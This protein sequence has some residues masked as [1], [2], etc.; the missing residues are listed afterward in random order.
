MYFEIIQHRTRCSYLYVVVNICMVISDLATQPPLFRALLIT[1]V[2][3]SDG[4]GKPKRSSAVEE[5][6]EDMELGKGPES[7]QSLG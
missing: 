7:R 2:G 5:D 4:N 3:S 6:T 1:E